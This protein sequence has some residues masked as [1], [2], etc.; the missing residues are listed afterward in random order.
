MT[1]PEPTAPATAHPAAT[2]VVVRGAGAGGGTASA[3][4]GR[5]APYEVMLQRR[6]ATLK[7]FPGAHVFPGGRVDAADRFADAAACCDGLAEAP[8]FPHL[9]ADG[10]LA[11]R[12]A[13]ARELLEE[14]GVL[15]ARRDGRWATAEEA[16]ALRG[17]LDAGEAF[18]ELV[19]EGGWRLALGDLVPFA[20]MV[21]PAVEPKRF[22]TH[23]FLA[24]L[25]A[26]QEARSDE[27]EA[28]DLVWISPPEAVAGSMGGAVNLVPPTWVT[29]LQLSPF[30]SVA[31]LLTWGRT[32]PIVRVE[33]GTFAHGDEHRLTFPAAAILPPVDG[34]EAT[35]DLHFSFHQ[36]RG[37]RFDS[38]AG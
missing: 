28:D 31:A 1:E 9:G 27:V 13:A 12:I 33:P 25:P 2:V 29:L 14:A 22:D 36:S 35:G 7:F 23:F 34:V 11:C 19:L 20:R 16:T 4:A 26:G 21:T 37:W 32:R 6:S 8:R 3:G 15:L 5:G 38:S 17:L 30:D 24:E 10:E 18:E